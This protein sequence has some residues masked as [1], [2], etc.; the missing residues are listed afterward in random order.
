MCYHLLSGEIL[1]ESRGACLSHKTR[2]SHICSD[3]FDPSRSQ[4]REQLVTPARRVSAKMLPEHSSLQADT[5]VGGPE[6]A[7]GAG[8]KFKER[9]AGDAGVQ[10]AEEGSRLGAGQQRRLGKG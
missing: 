2:D 6:S 4:F 3:P 8:S 9:R 5:F 10:F 7:T 1:E